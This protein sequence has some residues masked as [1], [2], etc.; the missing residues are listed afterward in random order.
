MIEFEKFFDQRI[1]NDIEPQHKKDYRNKINL[2]SNELHSINM[3]Q[4]IEDFNKYICLDIF[5]KYPYYHSFVDE[6]ANSIKVN[7]KSIIFTPGSDFG[8]FLLLT[9]LVSKTCK[10][11]NFA[12]NYASYEKYN[13]YNNKAV[14]NEIYFNQPFEK[15]MYRLKSVSDSIVILTNPNGF[16]GGRFDKVQINDIIS[17]CE[18]QNNLII[19]DETYAAFDGL[20]QND[21]LACSKNKHLIVVRSFSKSFGI[22]G[23][24]L[25]CIIAH[26]EITSYLARWNPTNMVSSFSLNFFSFCL[27]NQDLLNIIREEVRRNRDELVDILNKKAIVNLSYANFVAC[28]FVDEYTKE[29][30]LTLFANKNTIVKDISSFNGYANSLRITVPTEKELE[31]CEY[32]IKNL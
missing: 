8:I 30:A 29:R 32:V 9:A 7:N 24:R 17:I 6:Y 5:C 4:L 1:F 2:S 14:Y 20:E 13:L 27:K 25:G 19:L 31:I 26:P 12:P 15:I 3:N 28:R 16:D 21:L 22:A 10:V 11:V 18:Q 23:L